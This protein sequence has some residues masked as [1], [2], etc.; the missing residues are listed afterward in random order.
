MRR[1]ERCD[2]PIGTDSEESDIN[3]W[4]SSR[5][6]KSWVGETRIDTEYLR[7]LYSTTLEKSC[8]ELHSKLS[9]IGINMSSWN[10]PFIEKYEPYLLPDGSL[11]EH[12]IQCEHFVENIERTP[13]RESDHDRFLIRTIRENLLEFLPERDLKGVM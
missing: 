1:E 10:H 11:Q 2:M 12:N 8:Q 9:L 13:S 7:F 5:V 6:S 3:M 4:N